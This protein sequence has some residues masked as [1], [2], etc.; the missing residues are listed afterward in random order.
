MEKAIKTP[1]VIYVVDASV[2]IKWFSENNEDNLKQALKLQKLHLQRDCFLIAPDLLV[3]EVV[4]AL[5]H[6]PHFKQND[7]KTAIKSLYKMELGLMEP[8]E[9]E[10]ERAAD[11]AYEKN[12]TIYDASYVALARQHKAF[13]ITADMKFYKKAGDLPQII[14]LQD[15]Q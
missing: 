3:Y 12:I 14:A 5:R 8:G 15:L 7:T 1:P 13:L 9:K 11:L 4:N 6:N 2:V 10:I